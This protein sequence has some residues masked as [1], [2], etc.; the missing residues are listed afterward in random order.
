LAHEL[1][2]YAYDAYLLRCAVKYN[3]PLLSLDR[4]LIRAA[5]T[6]NALIIEVTP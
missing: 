6:L 4:G 3:A 5:Q 2:L 1:N